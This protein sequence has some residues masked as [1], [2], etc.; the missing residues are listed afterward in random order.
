MRVASASGFFQK[1]EM[2]AAPGSNG[3]RIGGG[4]SSSG[5][6]LWARILPVVGK[7]YPR[8]GAPLQCAARMNPHRLHCVVR[9]FLLALI[10][11]F[12]ARAEGLGAVAV[13][14]KNYVLLKEMASVYGAQVSGPVDRK[15]ALV[16]KWNTIQF[17]LDGREAKVNGT[18]VWLHEPLVVLRGHYALSET[19]ARMVID[20]LIRPLRHL[21][22]AGGRTVVIDAG[23]G[24]TDTG[25]S[26]PRGT[27]EKV[28]ALDIAQRL[29]AHLMKAGFQVYMTRESDRFIELEDRAE[30]A[31][32]WGAD[33]FVSIHLNSAASAEAS[34]AESFSMTAAGQQST[35]GGKGEEAGAGNRFD[36]M[37]SSLAYHVQRSIVEQAQVAD[38]GVK[39]ARFVVLKHA[40]CPAVLIETGF[41]SNKREEA[42]FMTDA[43]RENLAL[44]IARGIY[45]YAKLVRMA[46]NEQQ[47]AQPEQQTVREATATPPPKPAPPVE[48]PPVRTVEP[49][50]PPKAPR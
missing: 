7:C 1:V 3:W 39:K 26:G 15:V 40:P 4:K 30:R 23:H 35:S 47:P 17:T 38:R 27:V 28:L 5:W 19:D 14:R 48:P 31:K 45:N 22:A 36:A 16:S 46:R 13:D 10:P 8:G 33:I 11:V 32:R 34:G 24:G 12:C 42:R 20:P 9:L 2:M 41:V 6:N 37:N 25:C 18:S 43:F 50:R 44:G 29:R 21:K 49:T